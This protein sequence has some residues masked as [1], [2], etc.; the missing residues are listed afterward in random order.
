MSVK[1]RAAA[2]TR[3]KQA[4]EHLE[5][6]PGTSRGRLGAARDQLNIVYTWPTT[7]AVWDAVQALEASVVEVYGEIPS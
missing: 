3:A 6:H 5:Q 7:E 2:I 4:I 1:D